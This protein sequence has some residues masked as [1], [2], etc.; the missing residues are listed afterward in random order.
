MELSWK[1]ITIRYPGKA[2]V[3]RI[4]PLPPQHTHILILG[5]C[6]CVPYMAQG[7]EVAD[8]IK[9]ASQMTLR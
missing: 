2:L 6:D 4:M 7:I 3:D 8:R 1:S 5:T 9:A